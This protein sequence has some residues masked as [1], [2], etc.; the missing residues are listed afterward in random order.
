MLVNNVKSELECCLLYNIDL[1]KKYKKRIL[2]NNELENKLSNL[3]Y[4]YGLVEYIT[5][6]T[7]EEFK[8]KVDSL[9]TCCTTLFADLEKEILLQ[10]SDNDNIEESFETEWI[11]YNRC[12]IIV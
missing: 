6:E 12:C 10:N 8:V 4:L 1:S 9:C 3:E 5:L 7:Q 2:K 11:P